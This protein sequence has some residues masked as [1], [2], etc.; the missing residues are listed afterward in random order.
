MAKEFYRNAQAY[1]IAF[2]DREFNLECDF[3]EWI[4]DKYAK[5]DRED[6]NKKS[7]IELA[8]GPGRHAR[9]MVKRGWKTAA[10]DLSPE[11]AEFAALEAK[12]ENLDIKAIV[13][14]MT[15]FSTRIKY[16]LAATLMESISHLTTNEQMV[17][18]FKSVAKSLVPGGIYVIEATHPM[19]YFPDDEVNSWTSREGNTKVEITFG[20]PSDTYNSV[21]QVWNFTTKM[22]IWE[23]KDLINVSESLSPVRFYLAQEMKLLIEQSGAFD[24]YWMYGSLYNIPPKEM[25][26]SEDSDAM[27]IV[28][29]TK[30]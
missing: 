4:F 19:F 5:V 28:M 24:K 14:D 12:R 15:K 10:L 6:K 26:T 30:K 23:G 7:F 21:S 18:H 29:R 2:Q 22:R 11:M 3:L 20:V 13:A 1:D 27:V 16:S 17:S 9:E 8:C 25:D